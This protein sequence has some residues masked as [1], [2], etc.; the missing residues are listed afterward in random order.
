MGSFRCKRHLIRA[1]WCQPSS[2]RSS[3]QFGNVDTSHT[4]ALWSVVFGSVCMCSG[5]SCVLDE[6][7]TTPPTWWCMST[8]ESESVCACESAYL[9]CM[10]LLAT[11]VASDQLE[12]SCC[13][14]EF[15]APL[16]KRNKYYISSFVLCL[17]D[18]IYKFWAGIL[19]NILPRYRLIGRR[20]KFYVHEY[21]DVI[22]FYAPM[23]ISHADFLV[24]STIASV[25]KG[26]WSI[27][28]IGFYF[29]YHIFNFN[30]RTFSSKNIFVVHF[31]MTKCTK[32]EQTLSTKCC[33]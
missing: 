6:R 27:E 9:R 33:A 7:A 21:D 29:L 5:R 8:S 2:E 25:A 16:C 1:L 23:P 31:W 3:K 30:F 28:I 32:F 12:S 10:P 11:G 17:N 15:D 13:I 22:A 24:T 14:A 18:F 20:I 26:Q 4:H 19:W